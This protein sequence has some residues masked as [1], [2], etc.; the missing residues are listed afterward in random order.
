[1]SASFAAIKAG[2]ATIS[3]IEDLTVVNGQ[4]F[5]L[6]GNVVPQQ[7]VNSVIV[8][9]G[10]APSVGAV[11]Q[12]SGISVLTNPG[13]NV[14]DLNP[15]VPNSASLSYA[16]PPGIVELLCNQNGGQGILINAVGTGNNLIMSAS[17]NVTVGTGIASLGNLVL[18]TQGGAG[19]II[20]LQPGG[21]INI[22]G[23]TTVAGNLGV[24]FQVTCATLKVGPYTFP[25]ADGVAGQSLKTDGAG[26]LYWG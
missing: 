16:N 14:L 10:V 5:V 7:A 12:S 23:P 24:T 20:T 9:T 18:Q 19:A 22:Q 13:G 25:A 3:D 8:G 4:P 26:N 21:P 17:N 1:M 2:V 11:V 15:G 6:P